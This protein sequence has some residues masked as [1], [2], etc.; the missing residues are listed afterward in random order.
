[1]VFIIIGYLYINMLLLL[2]LYATLKIN[3]NT[4]LHIKYDLK[5]QNYDIKVNYDKVEIM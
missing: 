2:N 3:K 5:S 1:M 4:E